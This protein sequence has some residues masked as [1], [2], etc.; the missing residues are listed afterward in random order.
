M[1]RLQNPYS[2]N[3]NTEEQAYRKQLMDSVD[4]GNLKPP[5]GRKGWDTFF[6]IMKEVPYREVKS[7]DPLMQNDYDRGLDQIYE[8]R[9][10]EYKNIDWFN[11]GRWQE[12]LIDAL[13]DISKP[14]AH[15]NINSLIQQ[16][17]SEGDLSQE[18]LIEMIMP[19]MMNKVFK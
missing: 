9:T 5:D 7:K 8:D 2:K 4:Y 13:K 10:A 12:S 16:N 1:A 18:S 6:D 14:K 15:D 3:I 17:I 19:F 11:M